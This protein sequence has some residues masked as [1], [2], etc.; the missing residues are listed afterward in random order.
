MAIMWNK[1]VLIPHWQ[2]F[3][4]N[5]TFTFKQAGSPRHYTLTLRPYFSE[6]FLVRWIVRN[7]PL[8][9]PSRSPD[10]SPL[11]YSLPLY[12]KSKINKTQL[13]SISDLRQWNWNDCPHI[14]IIVQIFY[15]LIWNFFFQNFTFFLNKLELLKFSFG[16]TCV[17]ILI[18]S[19]VDTPS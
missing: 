10:L 4:N 2:E 11:I 7:E 18:T 3:L 1:K 15:P 14:N 13:E 16:E 19:W 8:D 5:M 17:F 6:K 9:W 12:L